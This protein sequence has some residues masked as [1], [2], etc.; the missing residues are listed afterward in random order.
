MHLTTPPLR[1][2]MLALVSVA[3]TLS[4]AAVAQ[5]V[6]LY[7][8]ADA[9]VTLSRS[10]APGSGTVRGLSSGVATASRWGIR[11]RED[12]GD[13]LAAIFQLEAGLDLDTG[14]TKTFS[15]NPSTATP[16][17][18]NGT[19][20]TGGFNRRSFV[21]LQGRFGT[22]AFGRDYTPVYYAGLEGDIQRYGLLGNLQA[23]VPLTG[24][25]ERWAR[26]SNGVFYTS[27]QWKGLT[28][29]AAYS[30]GSESGGG[31]GGL[32][33]RANQFVGVGGQYTGHGLTLTASYQELDYPLVGGTPA[34]FTG[35]TARRKDAMLAGRL[36]GAPARS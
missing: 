22:L 6:T 16:T 35:S 12:L 19:P 3:A 4:T 13:G 14:S 7:G 28:G 17:A 27:P 33:K 32:P 31:A 25:S 18:P 21:G 10:G 24:G 36:C 20:T 29:R 15:G 8:T 30:F 23:A 11:G 26:I 9:G 34:A 1:P 5:T 2:S